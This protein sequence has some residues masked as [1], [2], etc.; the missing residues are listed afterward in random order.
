[1]T[2][3][4][5]SFTNILNGEVNYIRPIYLLPRGRRLNSFLV[6]VDKLCNL[7][8]TDVDDSSKATQVCA[9]SNTEQKIY[10]NQELKHISSK[11]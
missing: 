10:M 11:D 5:V 3:S 7:S 2:I 8:N 1:M 9:L 4:G 6:G